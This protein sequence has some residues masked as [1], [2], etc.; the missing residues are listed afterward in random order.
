MPEETNAAGNDRK[1]SSEISWDK[2][3]N[4][5]SKEYALNNVRDKE[6]LSLGSLQI[7]K[8]SGKT[9]NI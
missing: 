7:G 6:I 2:N 1:F 9:L 8:A 4:Y 5:E 3:T